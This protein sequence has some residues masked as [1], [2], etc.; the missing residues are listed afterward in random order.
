MLIQEGSNPAISY[1]VDASNPWPSGMSTSPT[2]HVSK[3]GGSYGVATGT[4][5]FTAISSGM[6]Q[7]VVSWAVG[8]TDT[9]G[10][11]SWYLTDGTHYWFPQQPDVV[12]NYN[13]TD[14]LSTI[15]ESGSV[16]TS[17]SALLKLL[18][19]FISG[20]TNGMGTNTIHFRDPNDA[21][22]RITASMDA[23]GNRLSITRDLT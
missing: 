17:L 2:V 10:S 13:P 4:A 7:V 23:S 16:S 19:A 22:N 18:N 12:V 1:P 9:L 8:D 6:G 15:I 21:K 11:L 14:V 5:A 3:A 20:K